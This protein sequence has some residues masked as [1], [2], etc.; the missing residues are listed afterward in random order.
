VIGYLVWLVGPSLVLAGMG[1]SALARRRGP[2]WQRAIA[3]PLLA[4]AFT[5]ALYIGLSPHE[6]PCAENGFRRSE[7]SGQSAG[8][9]R[10]PTVYGYEAPAAGEYAGAI[11]VLGFLGPAFW[12]G[13]RRRLPA[14]T[15]GA[16]VVIVPL[17]AAWHTTPRGDND[18]LWV[19][20]FW[21]LPFV[22][23]L[24]ALAAAL[25][26]RVATSFERRRQRTGLP[27]VRTG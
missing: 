24:A 23:G 25:G 15:I 4:G 2:G 3:G 1:V 13:S 7:R 14:R 16:A 8:L 11:L 12:F 21:Y 6:D 10:C 19:L 5:W 20:I 9:H 17:L 18:G 26:R 22:G 27:P